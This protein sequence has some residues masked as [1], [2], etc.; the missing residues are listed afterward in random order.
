MSIPIERYPKVLRRAVPSATSVVIRAAPSQNEAN[1]DVAGVRSSYQYAVKDPSQ[2][3]GVKMV[4][5]EDLAKGYEYGRTAVH[6]SETDQ[7]ITKFETS[8][9]YEILGFVPVEK[10]RMLQTVRSN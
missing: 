10:V 5:R 7:N 6:I 9:S 8:A 1:N 2:T 3:G 4:E